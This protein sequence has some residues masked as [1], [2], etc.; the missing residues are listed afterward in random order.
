MGKSVCELAR[1]SGHVV[2]EID[3]QVRGAAE[4]GET[5]DKGGAVGINGTDATKVASETRTKTGYISQ[6]KTNTARE[7]EPNTQQVDVVID[8]SVA[9]ATQEV[10][11]FCKAHR[12]PLVTGTTGRDAEQQQYL[13]D[14]KKI[15]TVCEKANFSKGME[16]TE[17]IC[18]M[19]APLNWDCDIVE[20]HRKGKADRPSGTAKQL[21]RSLLLGGTRTVCVH[22]LR[23]GSNFGRH[24]I[25]FGT[26]GESITITHQAENVQIFARGALDTAEKIVIGQKR[27]D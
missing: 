18:K 6:I 21:C 5:R 14:L 10:C 19:L 4:I 2:V 16:L 8:F 12:C 25:V 23:N 20:T 24:E 13:E 11:E 17:E 1:E 27:N 15:T 7:I 26:N 3:K 22:S 9:E